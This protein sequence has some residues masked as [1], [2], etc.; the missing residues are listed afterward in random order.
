MSL[1]S[2]DRLPHDGGPFSSG[3]K[4]SRVPPA[5]LPMDAVD[6]IAELAWARYAPVAPTPPAA[7]AAPEADPVD[8]CIAALFRKCEQ[9]PA[10]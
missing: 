7:P 1:I 5:C 3:C 4:R 9:E 2:L 6:R 10:V 8:R